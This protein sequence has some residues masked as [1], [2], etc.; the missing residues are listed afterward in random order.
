MR[1]FVAA[2]VLTSA[3]AGTIAQAQMRTDLTQACSAEARRQSLSGD[4]LTGFMNKCLAGE[5]NVPPAMAS[6]MQRCEDQ[7]A[8]LSG[9]QKA[10]FLRDC[11]AGSM[12][13]ASPMQRCEDQAAQLSGEQKAKFV[14]DCMARK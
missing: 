4:A 9:E 11:K 10:M 14:R 8:Q 1:L 12:P 2:V 6:P 13:A 7:A 5:I 3:L